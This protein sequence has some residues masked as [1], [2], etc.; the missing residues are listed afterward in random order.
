M[1]VSAP[2]AFNSYSEVL[3]DRTVQTSWLKQSTIRFTEVQK[4]KE[5]GIW[6]KTLAKSQY[7]QFKISNVEQS[8]LYISPLIIKLLKTNLKTIWTI[9]T[10]TQTCQSFFTF[11]RFKKIKVCCHFAQ[12]R[13]IFRQSPIFEWGKFY[14]KKVIHIGGV[15]LST[16]ISHVNCFVQK[17]LSKKKFLSWGV[18]V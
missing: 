16:Q 18:V 8:I 7:Y 11:L 2:K 9:C 12:V 15:K 1:L 5:F 13:L 14:P 4:T 6:Y 10:Y 3:N 17:E